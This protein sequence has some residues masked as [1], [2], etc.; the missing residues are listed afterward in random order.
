VGSLLE[1]GIGTG[2]ETATLSA[3]PDRRFCVGIDLSPNMLKRARA[4]IVHAPGAHAVLCRADARSLPFRSG[5]FDCILSCYTL[6]LFTEDAISTVLG[7]F[8]RV[9]RSSRRM[10]L[11]VM[12]TRRRLPNGYG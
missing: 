11:V 4:Q 2:T 7:E 9:L 1:V 5:V 8:Q 10:V 3:D 6:D 12:G